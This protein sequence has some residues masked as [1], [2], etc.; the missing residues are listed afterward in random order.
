MLGEDRRLSLVFSEGG[1]RHP[2]AAVRPGRL[3][4]ANH[5]ESHAGSWSEAVCETK[6]RPVL[7]LKDLP[8]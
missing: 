3:S 4:A 5:E 1:A 8:T 7:P 2:T 6:H